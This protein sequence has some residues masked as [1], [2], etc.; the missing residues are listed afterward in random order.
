MSIRSVRPGRGAGNRRRQRAPTAPGPTTGKQVLVSLHPHSLRAL[1]PRLISRESIIA[2]LCRDGI[3]PGLLFFDELSQLENLLVHAAERCEM[4]PMTG[5]LVL[6]LA[7]GQ[8][9]SVVRRADNRSPD[10]T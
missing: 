8:S 1:G 4:R 10:L 5:R 9:N 2:L 3:R 7:H 6:L